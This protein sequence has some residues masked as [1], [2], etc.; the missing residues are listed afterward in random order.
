MKFRKHV[1][2]EVEISNTKLIA[3]LLDELGPLDLL[4]LLGSTVRMVQKHEEAFYELRSL[5]PEG[6]ARLTAAVKQLAER[7]DAE[8]GLPA[9]EDLGAE[10]D[11][12]TWRKVLKQKQDA[13]ESA[14]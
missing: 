2:A 5:A 14:R 8:K 3:R 11:V 4:H 13:R 7:M 1:E 12:E 6:Y 9:F 10:H